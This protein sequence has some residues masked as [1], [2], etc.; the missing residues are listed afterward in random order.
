MAQATPITFAETVNVSAY[1]Q[2][3]EEFHLASAANL[4]LARYLW[5]LLRPNSPSK[6]DTSTAAAGGEKPWH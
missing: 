1:V 6:S 4:V 3:S 5:G 2:L